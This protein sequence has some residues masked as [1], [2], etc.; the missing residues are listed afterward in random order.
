MKMFASPTDNAFNDF[1]ANYGF[2]FALA[3]AILIFIAV[4]LVVQKAKIPE[5]KN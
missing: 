3:L 2:Y 4:W 1:L 5:R